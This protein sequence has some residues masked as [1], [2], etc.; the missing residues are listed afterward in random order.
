MWATSALI[1]LTAR[2]FLAGAFFDVERH[3]RFRL[4]LYGQTRTMGQ[5]ASG[6]QS[7]EAANPRDNYVLWDM[8]GALYQ[9]T[10]RMS[11][12]FLIVPQNPDA[13]SP[14][15]GVTHGRLLFAETWA[16]NRILQFH[17]PKK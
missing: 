13:L 6:G 12:D 3:A 5:G 8:D 4:E 1:L 7:F 11:D 10:G 15:W 14:N 9:E 2:I 17:R 16:R